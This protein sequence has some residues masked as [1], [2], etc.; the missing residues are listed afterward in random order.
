MGMHHYLKDKHY[1]DISARSVKKYQSKWR[2][3]GYYLV[4]GAILNSGMHLLTKMTVTGRRNLKS[5]PTEQAFIVMSN[6]QSLYDAPLIV[7]AMPR[8]I[9]ARVAVGAA[10]D[11]FFR[12]WLQSKPTRILLNTYPIDRD[13]SGRH[14]GVSA[15]LVKNG[16]PIMVFP[17]GTRSRTGN[18][19]K[20][21][22]GLARIAIENQVP[23][24]P[25]AVRT[26]D[27]WPADRRHP[28]WNRPAVEVHFL[29]PIEPTAN[30]TPEQL[31]NRVRRAIATKLAS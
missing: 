21:H 22:Q 11:N 7:A 25:V 4:E 15:C 19:G 12:S 18:L 9:G 13:D 31:S 26:Y 28:H 24:V 3:L 27:A 16:T 17:E 30:E 23:I 8:K 10:T 1:T 5:L 2:Y 6:H 14:R 20:F 29:E